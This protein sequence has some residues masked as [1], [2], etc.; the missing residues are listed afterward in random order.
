MNRVYRIDGFGSVDGLVPH[1]EAIPQPGPHDIVVRTHYVSL[2]RRDHMILH[3]SYPLPPKAGVVPVSDGVG[4]VV[5][6]GNAVTRFSVGERVTGSYFPNWRDGLLQDD[7]LDQLGCTID[8]MLGQYVRLH[9]QWAVRVPDYLTPA[10][11]A[12]LTC[13]G[14]TAWNA[15][16]GGTLR[17]GGWVV[18][19][20]TGSV[21]LFALQ[22]ARLMNCRVIAVTSRS[23][24]SDRLLRL[25]AAHVIDSTANPEWGP[26]VREHTGGR[27]ADLVVET[28]GPDTLTQS[29]VASARYG[30]IVLLITENERTPD[31]VIPG[32]LY[33]R[34]LTAIRRLFVGNRASLEEMIRAM[35][36]AEMRP[37]IDEEFSLSEVHRAYEYLAAGNVFGNIVINTRSTSTSGSRVSVHG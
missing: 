8:G 28:R 30:E 35:E 9:E 5:A 26:I 22:F 36:T 25:G 23:E 31:L 16:T 33:A 11:A 27:G 6:I 18:T 20:G 29:M 17:P 19:I 12:T 13:G 32:H 37:V 24:K 3:N 15:I 7:Q 2:N 10:E 4:E 21:S 1:G 14:L 34:K